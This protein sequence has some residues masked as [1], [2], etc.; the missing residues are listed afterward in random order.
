MCDTRLSVYIGLSIKEMRMQSIRPLG[1][2]EDASKKLSVR[3]KQANVKQIEFKFDYGTPYSDRQHTVSTG[4][5]DQFGR[6]YYLT[7][8]YGGRRLCE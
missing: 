8:K 4:Q 7:G 6:H 2:E 5:S 3:F 1:T